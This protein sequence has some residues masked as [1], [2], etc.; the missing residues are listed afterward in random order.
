VAT[1]PSPPNWTIVDVLPL[2]HNQSMER[3]AVLRQALV[4]K[5]K[6]PFAARDELGGHLGSEGE[7]EGIP[8]SR[9]AGVLV[10]LIPVAGLAWVGIGWFLY[11][12]IA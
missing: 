2:F 6:P 7:S 8:K 4:D 1:A 12:L 9:L 5:V 10:L 3:F 11:R